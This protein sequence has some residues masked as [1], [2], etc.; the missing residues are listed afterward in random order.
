[1]NPYCGH[2]RDWYNDKGYHDPT[3]A[4]ALASV[5]REQNWKPCVFICSPFAGD[6][7]LNTKKAVEYTKFAV[8]QG[9]IPFAPHLL[10]PQVLDDSNHEERELGI[11]FGMVWLSKCEEIWVFG[12]TISSGM[13]REIARA[14]KRGL[15]IRYFNDKCEE[16]SK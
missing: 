14:E 8:E 12:D 6:V 16:V 11:F 2:K 13:E 7:E 15:I 4:K 3:A 1:M 9:V 10:Y 5:S